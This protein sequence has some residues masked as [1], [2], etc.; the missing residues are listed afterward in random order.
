MREVL[1]VYKELELYH[2][3]GDLPKDSQQR[4]VITISVDEK[5]GVQAIANTASDLPPVPRKHPA[6]GRDYEYKRMGTCSILA[7]L[8]LQGWPCVR[9]CGTVVRWSFLDELDKLLDEAACTPHPA[10]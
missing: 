3:T 8:D 10:P 5:P 6:V 4:T 9:L 1:L 7:G 2:Q